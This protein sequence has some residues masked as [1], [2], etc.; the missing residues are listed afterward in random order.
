[1]ASKD[2]ADVP[3]EGSK[4]ISAEEIALYDRQI[5]LWGMAAQERMRSARLLVIACNAVAEELV[6]NVVLAGIG[7]VVLLD[8]K[9]LTLED[10]SARF[11]ARPSELGKPRAEAI[12]ERA[13]ELNPR[14]NITTDVRAIADVDDA[15]IA[16]FECV[17][18]LDQD[19][20]TLERLDRVCRDAGKAFY[21]AECPGFYG[22]CFADLGSHDF[23]VEQEELDRLTGER[24]KKTISM[25]ED[26]PPLKTAFASN[27]ATKLRPKMLKKVMPLLP[28]FLT[29]LKWRSAHGGASPTDD[30]ATAFEAEVHKTASGLGLPD[31]HVA[32]ENI[33]AFLRNLGCELSAV[34]SV[35]GGV[36]GQDVLNTLS[37][38]EL[39]LQ[40]MLVF[41]GETCEAPIYRLH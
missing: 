30:D 10:L 36:L 9:T 32:E 20:D 31:G 11:L 13:R 26:F 22:Y 3:V 25:H 40:N 17:V 35:V 21:A 15:F 16:E 34:V 29:L 27:F 19:Y 18:A 4:G 33:T 7:S 1:M 5:R 6:K 41:D 37:R 14:V 12:A 2:T 23:V 8:E 39:P 24:K 38:R 28:C